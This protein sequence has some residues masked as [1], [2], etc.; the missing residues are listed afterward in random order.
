MR[1]HEDEL[2][3]EM[4]RLDDVAK[5]QRLNQMQVM[6]HAYQKQLQVPFCF[7]LGLLLC[8]LPACPYCKQPVGHL[9]DITCDGVQQEINQVGL[10]WSLLKDYLL[11]HISIESHSGT[12]S[13][14]NSG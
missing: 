10:P 11:P 12:C 9:G 6:E 7:M 8:A 14:C 3:A 5:E 1:Q 2:A 4:Q 13:P